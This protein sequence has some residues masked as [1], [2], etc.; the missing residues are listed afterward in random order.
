MR[1]ALALLAAGAPPGGEVASQWAHCLDRDNFRT[2]EQ[3]GELWPA[4][5]FAPVATQA[6]YRGGA[7][8][9][10]AAEALQVAWLHETT[11][12][13]VSQCRAPGWRR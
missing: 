4:A 12:G 1:I 11:W 13:A 2:A 5:E 8:Q 9:K 10:P 7:R 6:T 3:T